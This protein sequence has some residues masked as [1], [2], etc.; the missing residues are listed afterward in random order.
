MGMKPIVPNGVL[1][2]GGA[3]SQ[4]LGLAMLKYLRKIG[5]PAELFYLKTEM[6]HTQNFVF[7]GMI[8]FEEIRPEARSAKFLPKSLQPLSRPLRILYANALRIVGGLGFNLETHGH[9]SLETRIRGKSFTLATWNTKTGMVNGGIWPGIIGV[10]ATELRQFFEGS[11]LPNPLA[12]QVEYQPNITIHYRLGDMRTDRH[13]RKTHGVL[14]PAIIF[15]QVTKLW[16]LTCEKLP[17]I[18]YSDEPH[19]AAAL[20]ESVGLL[21]CIFV[22]PA[23]IWSD[24]KEMASSTYFI[25]SFSTVSSVVAEIRTFHN[26]SENILPMNC[27][28]HK[29]LQGQANS[30]YFEARTLPLRNSIYRID[31]ETMTE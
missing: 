23:N 16:E 27:R 2:A 8:D 7:D 10:V 18:V 22:V 14:D 24:V 4:L 28:R 1:I 13:W 11:P 20:L 6:S 3:T 15:K 19:V 25:G 5:V 9:E 30:R 31:S 12:P 21:E 29:V 26:L 17:I